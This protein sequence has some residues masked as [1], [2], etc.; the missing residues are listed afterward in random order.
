MSVCWYWMFVLILHFQ[1]LQTG[2]TAVYWFSKILLLTPKSVLKGKKS[3]IR[4]V[5]NRFKINSKCLQ[6][7]FLIHKDIEHWVP[8]R[9]GFVFKIF[10]YP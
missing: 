2:T 6:Q 1:I 7:F 4:V 8:T 5:L 10:G 3:K 9:W